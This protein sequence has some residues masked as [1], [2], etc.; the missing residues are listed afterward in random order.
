[1]K[2]AHPS[3][4]L[5]GF[6]AGPAGLIDGKYKE[7]TA[8]IIDEYRN[9]GGFDIIGSG[10]TKIQTEEQI[11]SSIETAKKLELDGL[12]II[13]GDDSNTNAAFLAEHFLEKG[14]KTRVIGVP[15]TIDGDLK[16]EHIEASFG[17]DTA[18]KIYSELIG[19]IARDAVSAKKY[20]HFIKLMGRSASHIA[21]ECALQT[22]PNVCL[23][24][25]EV[26]EKKMTLKMIAEQIAERVVMRSK[27]GQ[28]FGI[29]LVP[30]GLIEFVPEM[31]A[32]IAE[33]NEMMGNSQ[34]DALQTIDEKSE[35]VKSK[36]K[37]S[38]L[39]LFE[40]LPKDLAAQLLIDR[41]PHGNVQVSRIETEKLL[42][43]FVEKELKTL[44]EEGKYN[45]KFSSYSHFFGYEGR[46][47]FPSNFDCNYCYTLGY[48]AFLLIEAGYTGYI[49]SV[50][51]LKNDVRDWKVGAV[52]LVSM[53]NVERRSGKDKLVI[54]KALVE[55]NGKPFLQWKE[56][57]KEATKTNYRY[58]GSIQYFGPSELVDCTTLTLSL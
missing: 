26:E 52:P 48:T 18:T 21:L 39:K 55:L 29:V 51:N 8:N 9:T 1:M 10:R 32:L 34:F 28:D 54:K 40:S 25:E 37:T 7:L 12:V 16:N 24:S 49:V 36:L 22:H 23:I 6:L 11:A 42:I 46:S 4:I 57:E 20:W 19:N 13:G 17:F 41:D 14:L 53:L 47:A 3:S 44:K 56:I 35:A 31:K 33:L 15:K 58:P 2:K 50:K 45:G 27:D 30:E 38:S 5:Y 43:Y